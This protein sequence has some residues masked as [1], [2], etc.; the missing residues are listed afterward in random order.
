MESFP[1]PPIIFERFRRKSTPHPGPLSSEGRG[2]R[3]AAR[4]TFTPL[5]NGF[6]TA[7]FQACPRRCLRFR[8]NPLS[9]QWFWKGGESLR[10]QV[11]GGKSELHRARCCVTQ[12]RLIEIHAG[13]QLEDWPTE[14][15]TENQTAKPDASPAV[16][17][18]RWC[19]R[20][21]REAQ[22][23]RHGKPRREQGQI[24]NRGAARSAFRASE[25][26]SGIGR[27]DK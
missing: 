2:R 11:R 5:P 6:S 23:T 1:A 4:A 3:S 7:S 10:A 8:K 14:S 13:G 20:P 24:G 19:K 22:A 18:K 9:S 16:R 26:V 12:V 15:A 25:Q 17:V 21:P 27:S